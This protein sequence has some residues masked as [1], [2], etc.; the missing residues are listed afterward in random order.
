M[1]LAA[2]EHPDEPLAAWP[3]SAE[4][5][6][7]WYLQQLDPEIGAYN[8]LFSCTVRTLNGRWP[9]TDFVTQMTADYPLL[10][11]ALVAS[12]QGVQQR[13]V[14]T[15]DAKILHSDV[16]HLD[17]HALRELARLDSRAPFDLGN[18]GLWRVHLYRMSEDQYLLVLVMHHI[19]FDFWSMG[20]LLKEALTRLQGQHSIWSLEQA[21]AFPDYART[22]LDDERLEQLTRYWLAQLRGAPELHD[23]PL[24][25]PRP[26]KQQFQGAS[27]TFGLSASSSEAL[28]ARARELHATPYMMMLAI[29]ATFLGYWSAASEVV[30]S[31][32]VANRASRRVRNTLGQFVNTLCLRI[33]TPS[34][35]SFSER[36]EQVKATVTDAIRHQAMP[37]SKLVEALAPKRDN[38]YTAIAQ[39]GFSW[40]RLPGLADFAEFYSQGD[41]AAMQIGEHLQLGSFHV[42]QQEGQLDLM[43]EMG[44]ETDGAYDA[45]FKYNPQLFDASTVQRMGEFLITLA[46]RL[47]AEP[48]RPIDTLTQGDSE[49]QRQWRAAG[50][51]QALMLRDQSVLQHIAHHVR[52][53]P[54]SMAVADE[55][56]SLSYARLW[57]RSEQIAQALRA[58]GVVAGDRVGFKLERGTELTTTILGIWRL[59]ACY[60]PLDPHFPQDR[61]TYIA[62]DAQLRMVITSPELDDFPSALP[63]LYLHTL[64]STLHEAL[65][66]PS[67]VD[68]TAYILYTS[69]STGKPKG[70]EVGQQA[71]INFMLGM[72]DH[73]DFNP[74]TRL[75]AVT[76]P[77]FDISVLELF[78][79]LLAGG[80]SH[81]ADYPSTRDGALL[82]ELIEHHTIN[83]MQ[84]T[85]ATWQMLLDQAA[86]QSLRA[87]TALCGGDPLPQPLAERL[88]S[89]CA[90]AWN[91]YGPTETTIWS[92]LA[93]L[94]AGC[95]AS[96]GQPICN[97]DFLVL[98]EHRRVLPP[99]MLGEL[100]IGG[101]GLAKG[102]WQRP[103][104]SAEKFRDDLLAAP[105]R[106]YRTGDQ[107]RWNSRQQLEHLGR[108]DFQVK[109]RGYR[110]ELEE[111]Q[112]CLL[113]VDG[114][115]QAIAT[116]FSD[117]LGSVLV[118]Y[119]IPRMDNPPTAASL[120][121]HLKGQL[122][123]Y[124]VPGEFIFLSALPLTPNAKIDRQRLP[125]PSRG[126]QAE[127]QSVIAP[128]DEL[129]R[130]LSALFQ[131]VLRRT[132]LCIEDDFFE[133]GGH[134]LLAVELLGLVKKDLHA[135]LSVGELLDNPS[136]ASLAQRIREGGNPDR[137]NII[138]LRKGQ[139]VPIWLFHPIGGNVLSYRE[140]SR[141]L[142][143]T[144]PILALQSPGLEDAEAVE[145]TIEAMA[146]GYLHEIRQVQPQ[147]P[148]LLGG[149]CF[150]GAIAYEIGLQLE[151]M[152]ETV[153][154][155]FLID[156]RAPIAANVP[157][158]ADDSTLLSWFARDLATPH[159]KRWNIEPARLRALESDLAF[160]HVL[161]E[162][163]RL[164]VLSEQADGAQ[165]ARYFETYLANGIALQLYFPPPSA[166]AL[167]LLLARDE[168]ADYGPRLGWEQLAHGPLT[169]VALAGDH[170]SIMYAPQVHAVAEQ[171]NL[172][173][174]NTYVLEP[175]S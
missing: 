1:S 39:L 58:G 107:V 134:S 31:T 56:Q 125:A 9:D 156:T 124:M 71:L 105:G 75:L 37:F 24:D 106:W 35:Q 74:A 123:T 13:V 65:P 61:L 25:H 164:G 152:G 101:L 3:I 12:P 159:G 103:E 128:R 50:R 16:R 172:H 114:I 68:A 113:A 48:Q 6:G 122:P 60:V 40:E 19:A 94:Q 104:L 169:T 11:S 97:T 138:T 66:M 64:G 154:G 111:V 81:I 89:R 15:L 2:G 52:V 99:G 100:W 28:R 140:L 127:R 146:T 4:Q 34:T 131:K 27:H 102:Y 44:G 160:D 132:T 21:N 155:T 112:A 115:E 72:Q 63:R 121:Q 20:L 80:L 85:P 29:Y 26:A 165:L 7:L 162:G 110:I 117:D 109:L 93:R 157:D 54:D 59:G 137:G 43:L 62:E 76:T 47:L 130:Q 30:I 166:K 36:V 8:L 77:S 78:L 73:L 96:L 98:D 10:R 153:Q 149:W 32:P 120:K 175:E 174:L 46:E 129:E 150:G 23:L 70:V 108:L 168:E 45:I 135:T 51:G 57:Q 87:V 79:P 49:Q 163:K 141:H 171:L 158:D 136:V 83:A 147:G 42:P 145:V 126:A 22:A 53:R 18:P 161:V 69:G 116:V 5:K 41:S 144:R 88:L 151:A 91:L 92:S 95:P 86:P 84:A 148:Y 90:D 55:H 119:V 143:G 38:S 170:N 142:A 173:F 139:G 17:H 82:A 133:L 118:A 14:E 33:H 167:L 67:A